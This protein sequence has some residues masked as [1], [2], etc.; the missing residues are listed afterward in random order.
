MKMTLEPTPAFFLT[1]EGYPMRCWQ[2][3]TDAGTPVIAFIAAVGVPEDAGEEHHAALR[4]E[5]VS[6]PDPTTPHPW[7]RP[8]DMT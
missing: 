6:I 7:V 8:E 3:H 2:G 1:D 5:L 4:R